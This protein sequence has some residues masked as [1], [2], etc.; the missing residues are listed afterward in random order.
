MLRRNGW[1]IGLVAV[2]ID[3]TMPTKA[4]LSSH[5]LIKYKEQSVGGSVEYYA[6]RTPST[7]NVGNF[8][9]LVHEFS[10]T[11]G[12]VLG[13]RRLHMPCP[14]VMSI[15]SGFT[16]T[17]VGTTSPRPRHTPVTAEGRCG[18]IVQVHRRY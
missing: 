6:V 10:V 15:G 16:L 12:R 9:G 5:F 7:S 18:W 2:N 14:I 11:V 1:V 4:P 3:R 17:L 8:G 13:L